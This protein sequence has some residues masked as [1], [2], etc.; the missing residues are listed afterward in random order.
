MLL[1]LKETEEFRVS[2]GIGPYHQ[3]PLCAVLTRPP[4]HCGGMQ[5]S[6]GE[7][8]T[9]GGHR[10]S[11]SQHPVSGVFLPNPASPS[12]SQRQRLHLGWG[13]ARALGVSPTSVSLLHFSYQPAPL[14]ACRGSPPEAW[15]S[16]WPESCPAELQRVGK[17]RV[18][19]DPE[20][21]ATHN[22]GHLLVT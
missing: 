9:T 1:F 12:T 22:L 7:D 19:G 20:T 11:P 21:D 17:C 3:L 18:R 6:R 10:D 5:S 2:T 8:V 4:H 16:G 15:R 14:P 13:S